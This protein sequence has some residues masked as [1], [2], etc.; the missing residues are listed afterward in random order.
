MYIAAD[1]IFTEFITTQYLGRLFSINTQVLVE[2]F[3]AK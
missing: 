2:V 3:L 1:N